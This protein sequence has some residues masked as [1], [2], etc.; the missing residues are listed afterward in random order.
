VLLPG[1]W[2][3]AVIL[4][5]IILQPHQLVGWFNIPSGKGGYMARTKVALPLVVALVFALAGSVIAYKWV[6]SQNMVSGSEKTSISGDFVKVAVAAVQIPWGTKLSVDFVQMRTFL[7]ESLPAGSFTDPQALA[8]R[9]L[10]TPM[11][12]GDII[13]ESKLA[14]TGV[15]SG[16][17]SAVI[18]PGNRAIA[19]KGDKIVGLAG[20]IKPMDRVDVLVTI[21]KDR[22]GRKDDPVTKIVLE[23]ILVLAAGTQMQKDEKGESPVDVY[24]LEVSPDDAER[25]ALASNEGKLHFALRNAL[26]SEIVLTKGATVNNTLESYRSASVKSV[27]KKKYARSRSYPVDIIRGTS[28]K[29]VNF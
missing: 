2:R 28:R 29:K 10:I 5:E 26:D 3:I 1:V 24:T 27:T 19:V 23:N 20:L 25:L 22:G 17:I 14:P 12:A 6:Q 18:A 11:D 9:V 15:T 7:V 8:E 4:F 13:L 21:D 16:G